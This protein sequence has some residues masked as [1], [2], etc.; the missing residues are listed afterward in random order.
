[1]TTKETGSDKDKQ[2]ASLE[3]RITALEN[4]KRARKPTKKKVPK[5]TGNDAIP[6]DFQL[7]RERITLDMG[8]SSQTQLEFIVSQMQRDMT[9]LRNQLYSQDNFMTSLK[10]QLDEK[11]Q[12]LK[13]LESSTS[14]PEN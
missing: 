9:A 1:M 10:S 2:I 3:A 5:A 6:P 4:K 7:P 13:Q 12:R 14:P 8:S 11:N